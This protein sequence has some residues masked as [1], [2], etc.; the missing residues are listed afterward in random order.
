MPLRR[1]WGFVLAELPRSRR[2]PWMDLLV[3]L[4]LAGLVFGSINLARQ[5]TQ[6]LRPTIEIDLD[7]PWV[8]I[9][10]TF[11]S[12]SRGLIAYCLSLGFTLVYGCWAAK[13]AVAERIL[14]PLLDI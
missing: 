8:L 13:D 10:Y 11:F 5:W 3:I 14:V 7:N 4:G 9:E 2:L 6:E 12:L 1:T